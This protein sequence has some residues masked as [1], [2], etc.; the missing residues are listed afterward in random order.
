M[1]D[2]TL[3]KVCN[4]LWESEELGNLGPVCRIAEFSF[5]FELYYYLSLFLC[6]PV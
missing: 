1:D 4:A 5:L 2:L 6:Y 3:N